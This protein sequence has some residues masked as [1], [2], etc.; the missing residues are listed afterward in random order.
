MA[1]LGGGGAARIAMG[2]M[3][4]EMSWGCESMFGKQGQADRSLP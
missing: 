1:G 2:K 4:R 3:K